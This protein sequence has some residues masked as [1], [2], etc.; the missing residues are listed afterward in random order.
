MGKTAKVK[1]NVDAAYS[2]AVGVILRDYQGHFI[3]AAGKYIPHLASVTMAE[4][5]AMKEG[6]SLAVQRGCN[7]IIAESDSLEI[8]EACTG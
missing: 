7:L 6:L 1:E 8:I 3:A 2:G 4:A 5:F